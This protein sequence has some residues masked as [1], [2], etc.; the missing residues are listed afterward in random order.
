MERGGTAVRRTLLIAGLTLLL[1]GCVSG[2]MVEN[3]VPLMA[4]PPGAASS[5]VFLPQSVLGYPRVFEKSLDVIGDYFEI[6]PCGTN[7]YA[8]VIRTLPKIAPGI[9]QPWKPGS[10]SL[11]QRLLAFKQT[12]RHRAVVEIATGRDGGYFVD[13]KVFNELEDLAQPS[14]VT[15]GM[16]TFRLETTVERQFEVVEPG[17]FDTAWIP[18]GRDVALEQKILERIARLDCEA[19]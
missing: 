10:P 5:P 17:Q 6:D 19:K 11:Y 14:R 16:A 13:V 7:R 18:I 3:P 9:E 15:A 1:G 2:P 8:G 4:V 12:I